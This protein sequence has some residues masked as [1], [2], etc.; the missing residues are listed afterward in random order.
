VKLFERDV[1]RN[2]ENMSKTWNEVPYEEYRSIV[3]ATL[4]AAFGPG[5]NRIPEGDL[6]DFHKNNTAPQEVA[7]DIQLRYEL[8]REDELGI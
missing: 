8:I 4:D 2:G 3:E 1:R 5:Y 6:G 7:D